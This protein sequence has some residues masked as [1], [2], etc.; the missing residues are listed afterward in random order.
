MAF[1]VLTVRKVTYNSIELSWDEENNND[2]KKIIYHVQLSKAR[3]R[4]P[5]PG[6]PALDPLTNYQG[7][8]QNHVFKGLEPQTEY[9]CRVR[10]VE[11]G[12]GHGSARWSQ[13]SHVKTAREPP[14]GAELHR[15]VANRDIELVKKILGENSSVVEVMDKHG[16]TPLMAA[17]QKDFL[18][19]FGNVISI[20]RFL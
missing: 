12:L 11:E 5:S 20:L 7:F 9:L 1:P 10:F 4:S 2:N 13:A 17:A 19:K 8:G 3:S 16:L 18:G 6:A 15:A 14:S